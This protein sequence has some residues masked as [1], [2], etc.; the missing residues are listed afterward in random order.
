MEQFQLYHLR[1]SIQDETNIQLVGASSCAFPRNAWHGSG[2]LTTCHVSLSLKEVKTS[3]GFNSVYD[4]KLQWIQSWWKK[5]GNRWYGCGYTE[6]SPERGMFSWLSPPL[7]P[8]ALFQTWPPGMQAA[9]SAGVASAVSTRMGKVNQTTGNPSPTPPF[10]PKANSAARF[11]L[12]TPVL[13]ENKRGRMCF[14]ALFPCCS[15]SD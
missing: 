1:W 12:W 14:F 4:C 13:S 5:M 10:F 6:S 3:I 9:A 15:V 2:S 8:L 7:P 11:S